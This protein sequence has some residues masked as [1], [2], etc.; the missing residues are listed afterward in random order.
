MTTNKLPFIIVYS[1]QPND[2]ALASAF[3]SD[4]CGHG[5][6]VQILAVDQISSKTEGFLFLFALEDRHYDELCRRV[7]ELPI[8]SSALSEGKRASLRA[9]SLPTETI[10]EVAQLGADVYVVASEFD[11]ALL[12]TIPIRRNLRAVAESSYGIT[13]W[14]YQLLEPRSLGDQVASLASDTYRQLKIEKPVV[15]GFNLDESGDPVLVEVI[16]SFGLSNNSILPTA[17]RLSDIDLR[18][19]LAS[20][21]DLYPG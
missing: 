8:P 21:Y 19:F 5:L 3:A 4:L 9:L 6:P 1:N 7:E 17:L 18:A 20:V 16:P 11:G 10:A 2:E 12:V 15:F 13:D 14:Q